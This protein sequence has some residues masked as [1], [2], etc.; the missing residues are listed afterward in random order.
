LSGRYDTSQRLT[1][2]GSGGRVAYLAPRMLPQAPAD[3]PATTSV[4]ADELHRLD[5][6]ANRAL[7]NSS[8]AWRIADANNAMDPFELTVQIGLELKLPGST[9]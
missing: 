5:L 2:T 3:P 8:L 9:L 6:V 4:H 1:Y 7:G